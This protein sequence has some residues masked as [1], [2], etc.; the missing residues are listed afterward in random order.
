[1]KPALL[2]GFGFS[3][4]PATPK[5]PGFRQVTLSFAFFINKITTAEP[6]LKNWYEGEMK[7]TLDMTGSLA[8]YLVCAVGSV[9]L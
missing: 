4:T 5:L 6:A 9:V 1:M 2:K 3:L 7:S 8:S